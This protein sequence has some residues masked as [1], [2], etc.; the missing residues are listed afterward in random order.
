MATRR[1]RVTESERRERVSQEWEESRPEGS[2]VILGGQELART[3]APLSASF[4][5]SGVPGIL[6]G[7]N[8]V[9]II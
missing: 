9:R 2:N 1:A 4:R 5:S 6:R 7:R 3:K 8:S